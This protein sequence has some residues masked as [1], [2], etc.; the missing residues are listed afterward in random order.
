MKVSVIAIALA[1]PIAGRWA[2]TWATRA[3]ASSPRSDISNVGRAVPILALIALFIAFLG[4]GTMNV[5]VAL[6][7][8][9]LPPILTNTYVGARQVD[10][11]VVDAAR[12]HGHDRAQIIWQVRLPLALPTYFGGIRT[13]AVSVVAT[14]T[15]GPLSN[16]QTLGEPIINGRVRARP[17]PS[18]PPSSWPW[19]R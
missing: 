4:I 3:G 16:V 5:V 11:E 1:R 2:S 9:A 12:G 17:A 15:I 19:W 14:A 18:G 13:S 7:L 10:P 8:L 6:T